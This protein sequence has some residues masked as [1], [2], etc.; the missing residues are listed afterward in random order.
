MKLGRN[1][2]AYLTLQILQGRNDVVG[3]GFSNGGG[4]HP[5]EIGN[6]LIEDFINERWLR[7]FG[8]NLLGTVH[9]VRLPKPS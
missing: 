9:L 5:K 1:H 3:S 7:S 8:N 6:N 4:L 2:Y